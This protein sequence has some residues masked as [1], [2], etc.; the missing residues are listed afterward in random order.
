MSSPYT[1]DP[2][3]LDEAFRAL[4][5]DLLDPDGPRLST[6]RSSDKFAI[7]P[8]SP[9]D[10]LALRRHAL[11]LTSRLAAAGWRVISLSLHELFLE[12]LQELPEDEREEIEGLEARAVGRGDP[13]KAYRTLAQ[14]IEPLIEGVGGLAA[15]VAARI[16]AFAAGETSRALVLVGR[17]GALHPFFRASSLLKYL[18]GRTRGVPVVLLYPGERR[19]EHGL[20][21]MNLLEPDRDYRPRIYP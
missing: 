12:I 7:V 15:R 20:S 13:E 6:M 8:Y 9:A 4:T 14:R 3:R 2:G 18:A 1:H 19:G 10:E 16:E 5:A 17:A 11:Q 21:Y